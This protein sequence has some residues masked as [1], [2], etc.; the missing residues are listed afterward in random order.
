MPEK[1]KFAEAPCQCALTTMSKIRPPKMRIDH[2]AADF[3]MMG[4]AVWMGVRL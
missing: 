1:M 2:Q 4:K 3:E